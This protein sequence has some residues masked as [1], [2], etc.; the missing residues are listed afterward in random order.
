MNN[1]TLGDIS[2]QFLYCF[3]IIKQDIE[4]DG[5]DRCIYMEFQTNSYCDVTSP[6]LITTL[7]L[8]NSGWND[9]L[10]TEPSTVIL[11]F[12][13]F[14]CFAFTAIFWELGNETSSQ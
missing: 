3:A 4:R 9:A 6:V 1:K 10:A 5:K 8:G 11:L 14:G 13:W 7:V 12:L 2:L